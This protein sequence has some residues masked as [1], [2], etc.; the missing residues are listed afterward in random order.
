MP[1]EITPADLNEEK[2][3]LIL[4]QKVDGPESL[5]KD[6]ETGSEVY[7]LFGRYGPYVQLGEVSDENPKP[8]KASPLSF[9]LA[10]ILMR[11]PGE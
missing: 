8:K 2:A 7:L 5:G 11:I 10:F 4:K 6:I 3:E 1:H 9:F